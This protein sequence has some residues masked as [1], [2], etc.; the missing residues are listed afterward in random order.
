MGKIEEGTKTSETKSGKF[1]VQI[2]DN[3]ERFLKSQGEPYSSLQVRNYD[4][5][6]AKFYSDV[7]VTN[8]GNGKNVW[9]EVKLNKYACLG[10]P[11]YRFKD[12]KW[13]CTTTDGEDEL[14]KLYLD[15]LEKGS[16]K[17]ISFCRNYLK[18]D[19]ISIPKDLTPELIQAWKDSGSVE[20]TENDVQFI[21]DKVP[22]EG[23]GEKIAEYYKTAKLEP[24][25]YMQVG[26]E[27]YIVDPER[28]PLGLRTRDGH[29]LKS[30]A[31]AYRIG[32]IQF[33]AKGIDKKLKDGN[34]YYYSIVCDVKIL[35]DDEK[36]DEPEYRCSFKSEDRFPVAGDAEEKSVDDTVNESREFFRR[37]LRVLME[38]WRPEFDAKSVNQ[39]GEEWSRL[40]EGDPVFRTV[41][42]LADGIALEP[43]E[44]NADN[45]DVRSVHRTEYGN[46][47]V[48]LSGGCNGGT[49]PKRTIWYLAAVKKL[50]KAIFDRFGSVWLVD[51]DNDCADDVF[52]LRL[53]FRDMLSATA[54]EEN[55]EIEGRFAELFESDE[56]IGGKKSDSVPEDGV[57]V[58]ID[59]IREA[60]EGF[61]RI[62]SVAE[63]IDWCC[64]R[65]GIDDVTLI[66]TDHDAGEFQK[67]GGDYVRCF[68]YLERCGC[69]NV[70][71]HIHSANPVG[72]N[73]IRR[74]IS[75]NKE[76]GWKEI[77][78][79]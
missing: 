28:N 47:I 25:Y 39:F 18:T 51:W 35:A 38:E 30:L 48:T 55:A 53:S 45:L 63:F 21:T 22:L 32:R 61:K 76:N 54:D 62:K 6:D 9:F 37:G 17:F 7:E 2:R 72:A 26:D 29:D 67:D 73:N 31:D 13:T 56:E 79:S 4:G 78:N 66:D 59:D 58:W 46:Y 74:I 27:L 71:V 49:D 10:G 15:A 70:T 50:A 16:V 20:D 69:G 3:I 14:S 12:G 52:T 77:R 24:V 19:D 1:E 75:R 40:E 42:A 8:P 36:S 44:T 11:S 64:E 65:G 41:K 33:R 34:K 23:F 57:K 5:K 43:G 60:P 68:D